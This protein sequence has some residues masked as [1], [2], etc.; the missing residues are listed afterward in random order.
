MVRIE[1][2][3]RLTAPRTTPGAGAGSPASGSGT[4]EAPV[5]GLGLSDPPP[6]TLTPPTTRMLPAL[7]APLPVACTAVGERESTSTRPGVVSEAP[8]ETWSAPLS[9][10][11]RIRIEG[12]TDTL[13]A[14]PE[15]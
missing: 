13:T 10:P 2:D 11:S 9:V 7:T 15:L 12:R 8:P 6:L 14:A 3:P 5:T 1:L 4:A